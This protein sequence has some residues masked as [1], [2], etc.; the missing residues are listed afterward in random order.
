MLLC[1]L[2]ALTTSPH[3]FLLYKLLVSFARP[4]MHVSLSSTEMKELLT[5][6]SSIKCLELNFCQVSKVGT[7]SGVPKRLIPSGTH[8]ASFPV[9][10]KWY[11]HFLCNNILLKMWNLCQKVSLVL[12]HCRNWIPIINSMVT[13]CPVD[14][15][16]IKSLC[17]K[18]CQS[19]A[20]ERHQWNF[21]RNVFIEM[22]SVPF[23][24][25]VHGFKYLWLDGPACHS[26]WGSWTNSSSHWTSHWRANT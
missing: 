2:K 20:K 1:Y 9:S 12:Q 5:A 15:A 21:L 18:W 17:N 23:G 4:M 16:W 25:L 14:L 26:I 3:I 13:F 10:T 7:T 24:F 8:L 6:G 22:F 11:F 19:W